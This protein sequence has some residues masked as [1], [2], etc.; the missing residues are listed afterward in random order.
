[1]SGRQLLSTRDLIAQGKL[2]IND[3]YRAKN[4]ELGSNGIPFIRVGNLLNDGFQFEDADRFPVENLSRVGIKISQPGDVVLTTKGTVG[5]F[6]F[7]REDTQRFVYSPQIS[8]WRVIDKQTLEPR[9]LY[10]WMQGREFQ[11]QCS[12]VKGQTDMADYVSL[13]EQRQMQITLPPLPTQRRIAEILGRL[14]DKI[15]VNR[16]INRTLEAMAQ[17]LFQHHFVEF[18]P[19]QAELVESEAGLIPRG[20][21]VT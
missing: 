5:R 20:W 15:E 2:I 14:D 21:E 1:M 17:A 13:L 4:I 10:Y 9:F 16:R 11:I 12:Q 18:G 3:G 8:F 7:I 19:Y 6:A